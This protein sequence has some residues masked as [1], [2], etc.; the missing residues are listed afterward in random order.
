MFL[1]FA[2]NIAKNTNANGIIS[3]KFVTV[4]NFD[5]KFYV[6]EIKLFS[7]FVSICGSSW[8]MICWILRI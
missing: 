2:K 7:I 5:W 3:L 1:I 4:S 8:I 6:F